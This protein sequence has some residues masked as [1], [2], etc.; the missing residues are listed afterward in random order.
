MKYLIDGDGDWIEDLGEDE[1]T[2][3]NIDYGS[4][5]CEECGEEATER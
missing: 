1:N 5:T 3:R 4:L 2:S